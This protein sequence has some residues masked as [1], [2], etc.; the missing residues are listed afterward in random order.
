MDGFLVIVLLIL[1]AVFI[2]IIVFNYIAQRCYPKSS[3]SDEEIGQD[4]SLVDRKTSA[5]RLENFGS[6]HTLSGSC[7]AEYPPDIDIVRENSVTQEDDVRRI[8][9]SSRGSRKRSFSREISRDT[10]DTTLPGYNESKPSTSMKDKCTLEGIA[11]DTDEIT[12]DK[13]GRT[14]L[15]QG[16]TVNNSKERRKG[17]VTQSV[18]ELE[19]CDPVSVGALININKVEAR[20]KDLQEQVDNF[21]FTNRGIEYYKLVEKILRL[22]IDLYAVDCTQME[23]KSRRNSVIRKI[24]EYQI[25]LNSK[26]DEEPPKRGGIRESPS[27]CIPV[28]KELQLPHTH[29]NL[30]QQHIHLPLQSTPSLQSQLPQITLPTGDGKL[31]RRCS[32]IRQVEE[33]EKGQEQGI[34]DKCNHICN[35]E[36]K[37]EEWEGSNF[38][39][40]YEKDFFGSMDYPFSECSQGRA[41]WQERERGRR[42]S[43]SEE[44]RQHRLKQTEAHHRW[45]KRNRIPPDIELS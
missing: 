27:I 11:E 1:L 5:W 29:S 15:K 43:L 32:F 17:G 20:T 34:L 12:E 6:W 7:Y 44:A 8:S 23:V 16:S 28:Q 40:E 22:K 4:V 3:T 37:K 38:Y 35:F 39:T 14:D 18:Y 41:A 2:S 36:I 24:D 21:A 25:I 31:E 42:C 26:S 30:I 45:M 10:V 9:V 19:Y 33:M 13:T